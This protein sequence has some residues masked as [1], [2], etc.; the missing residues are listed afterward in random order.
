MPS[1]TV[2]GLRLYYK[3]VAAP[4]PG[5]P[6]GRPEPP[7]LVL[8]HGLLWSVRMFERMASQIHGR[9]VLL[10]D[11]HGHGRSDK[12]RDAALYTWDAITDDIVGLLDHL[13]VE[14]AV[15]GGHS[16]GANAALAMAYRR[17]DR[18][19]GLVLE[20][21]VLERGYRFGRPVFT[22]L[23]KAYGTGRWVL[24]PTAAAVR[25]LPLPRVP[26]LAG[27][28]DVA[29]ADPA[30]ASAI[31]NGLL[32]EDEIPSDEDAVRRIDVPVLLV[33]HLRDPLH[34][35]D[36]ARDLQ[37]R[38]PVARLVEVSSI[39]THRL[40][41]DRLAAEVQR[42]LDEDVVTGVHGVGRDGKD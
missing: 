19:A 31:L 5:A 21:P 16:L 36:D 28:R 27:L 15:V 2:D 3:D 18:L 23:S 26:E 20:M 35:I 25:R 22:A 14:R 6:T 42:F 34:A 41:A 32:A 30:V 13:G 40:H 38:L 33:A 29:G 7:P 12:P 39:L 10:L 24:G 4:A 37:R 8:V 11:V 9:R 17:P 1:F